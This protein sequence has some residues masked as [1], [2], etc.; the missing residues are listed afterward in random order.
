MGQARD[1]MDRLTTAMDNKDKETLARCYAA[2]AVAY[3]PDEGELR[4]RDAITNYLFRF[5][6]SM[7]DVRYEPADSHEAGDVAI[8]E[9]F[10]VGTNTGPLHMPSGETMPATGK[11]IRV[12]S[13][14]I[15]KVEGGEIVSHHFYFDQLEFL[16]QLG[17]MRELSSH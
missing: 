6:E 7:P 14:D 17:L 1:V 15:A 5:W 10:V 16:G 13:C 2:N 8:D 4:G 3:T 12:R 11:Q 9:G